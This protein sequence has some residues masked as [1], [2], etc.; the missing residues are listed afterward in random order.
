MRRVNGVNMKKRRRLLL[1]SFR[2]ALPDHC[3]RFTS[4]NLTG[5]F[6]LPIQI[7]TIIFFSPRRA[8]TRCCN[9]AA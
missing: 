8:T 9:C 5:H 3:D 2:N 6:D 4:E 1:I 7:I